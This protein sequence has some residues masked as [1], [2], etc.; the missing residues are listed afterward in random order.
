M[1]ITAVLT[2]TVVYESEILS[3]HQLQADAS[4]LLNNLANQAADRGLMSGDDGDITVETW[5]AK[6][7]VE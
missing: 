1:K 5:N 3:K 6:V 4:H 2:L 7:E